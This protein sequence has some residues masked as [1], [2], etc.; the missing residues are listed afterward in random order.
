MT[1]EQ[2]ADRVALEISTQLMGNGTAAVIA[3]GVL[4]LLGPAPLAW[5]DDEAIAPCGGK[6]QLFQQAG[7]GDPVLGT[8]DGGGSFHPDFPAAKAAAE[9]H[10]R[11]QWLA[12]TVLGQELA[13]TDPLLTQQD[14]TR[15]TSD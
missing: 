6:Y 8:P 7:T 9:A 1:E 5:R 4:A 2:I 11:A 12:G 14:A 15:G 10:H 13:E 3:R